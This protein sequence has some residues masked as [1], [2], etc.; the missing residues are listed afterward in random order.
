MGRRHMDR[1]ISKIIRIINKE[2]KK[3]NKYEKYSLD[4]QLCLFKYH[5]VIISLTGETLYDNYFDT[6]IPNYNDNPAYKCA[7]QTGDFGTFKIT[8]GNN[9]DF[10]FAK[11]NKINVVMI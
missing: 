3:T 8:Y 5:I 6:P 10:Y 9:K 11:F 7:I 1:H 2:H 4:F